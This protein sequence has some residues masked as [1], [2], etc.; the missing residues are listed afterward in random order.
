MVT[1][2]S[3]VIDRVMKGFRGRTHPDILAEDIT[4][5]ETNL[6]YTGVIGSGWAPGTLVEIG[7]ELILVTD[8]DTTNKIATVQRGWLNTTAE[9]HSSG[10]AIYINPRVLRSDVLA[11][12]N[13]SLEDMFGEGLFQTGVSEI[14]YNPSLIG[15]EIPS[16]AVDILRVDALKDDRAKYWEPV[17]DWLEVDN[18]DTDD[19]STGS[20]IMLR[21][22]LPPGAFRVV[23]TKTFTRIAEETDDLE[24]D[25]G[26]R[27]YMTDLPFYFAMNRLMV[28]LERHRSQIE[29]AESHQ[30]AQDAP[31]FLAIRTGEWYQ[32]RYG[33]R[34]RTSIKH[35]S[36][37]VKKVRATGYGS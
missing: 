26:L 10:D 11:L 35:Q 8:V 31:P 28:D 33:D 21:T 36:L 5:S 34:L 37:E 16:E 12:F 7:S 23:Y 30:R 17:Y 13:D 15:Y 6:N 20:A 25:V 32:A 14:T 29:S 24:A 4:D 3:T 22:A 18:T 1:P 2:T 9:A 27:P 19:F